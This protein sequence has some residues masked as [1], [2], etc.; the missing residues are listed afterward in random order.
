MGVTGWNKGS[1]VTKLIMVV[2]KITPLHPSRMDGRIVDIIK[3]KF[4]RVKEEE[5]EIACL[6][7]GTKITRSIRKKVCN[8]I[9]VLIYGLYFTI[10][11]H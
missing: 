9:Y 3:R 1:T 11:I 10:F 6:I 2:T 5:I 4:N 8:F 7:T